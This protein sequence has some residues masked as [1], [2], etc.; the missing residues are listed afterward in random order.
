M[1]F[2]TLRKKSV[3]FV[4]QPYTITCHK[5]FPKRGDQWEGGGVEPNFKINNIYSGSRYL[6]YL[7][8]P[9]MQQSIQS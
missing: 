2:L 5:N 7:T 1:K 4:V 3:S 8:T 6:P 9:T